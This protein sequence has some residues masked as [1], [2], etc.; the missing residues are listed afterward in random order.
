MLLETGSIDGLPYFEEYNPGEPGKTATNEIARIMESY[1]SLSPHAALG[2]RLAVVDAPDPAAIVGIIANLL[3]NGTCSTAYVRFVVTSGAD[4]AT[5]VPLLNMN[6]NDYVEQVIEGGYGTLNIEIDA[7][8]QTYG[9]LQEELGRQP[10]HLVLLFDPSKLAAVQVP[11]SFSILSP[12][13]LPMKFH[14]DS[15]TDEVQIVPSADEG[16]FGYYNDIRNRL[17]GQLS[18]LTYGAK[19]SLEGSK[20]TVLEDLVKYRHATWLIVVDRPREQH[21]QFDLPRIALLPSGSRDVQVFASSL[22]RFERE[23]RLQLQEDGYE[24]SEMAV[25][26]LVDLLGGL[27]SDGL[28]SLITR[29]RRGDGRVLDFDTSG[30]HSVLSILVAAN[31][32]YEHQHYSDNG[33]LLVGLDSQAMHIWFRL[34]VQKGRALFVGMAV[35]P[36]D[37]S[38]LYVDLLEVKTQ[39]DRQGY[40][41]NGRTIAGEDVRQLLDVADILTAIFRLTQQSSDDEA[42]LL[43]PARRE[44]LRQQLFRECFAIEHRKQ[45][46]YRRR[47]SNLLNQLFDPAKYQERG[48]TLRLWLIDVGLAQPNGLPPTSSFIA[49]ED[50][51]SVNLVHILR[52]QIEQY[53]GRGN[54]EKDVK[55]NASAASAEP[56]SD[57]QHSEDKNVSLELEGDTI[58]ASPATASGTHSLD[59]TV[60]SEANVEAIKRRATELK[61]VLGE[62]G[63]KLLDLNP[64][65]TQIGPSVVR[66]RARLAPG[67]KLRDV[68][69]CAEDVARGLSL[70]SI[71]IIN[72]IPGEPFVAIDIERTDRE[73]VPLEAVLGQLP[74]VNPNELVIACG[75]TPAGQDVP[76]DIVRLPHLLVAGT[77]ESGKTM[78]LCTLLI[79]LLRRY[80]E[81]SLKLLLIDPKVTNFV[82]FEGL[83]HL[84]NKRIYKDA[85]EATE[86]LQEV[87][88]TEVEQRTTQLTRGRQSSISNYNMQYPDQSIPRILV[89]VDEYADLIA[90]LNKTQR[91]AFESS[92]TRLTQRMRSVGIHLVLATQR[93]SV[94]VVTGNLKANMPSRIS[95]LLPSSIDSR[96]ILDQPGAEHLLGRGDMLLL[97][98]QRLQRLQGYFVADN[99]IERLIRS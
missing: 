53:I 14:Y 78:F 9:K 54:Q 96:T 75:R 8:P 70:H 28:L 49:E 62:Y 2:L 16:L 47:W 82:F 31:W 25:K 97:H 77:T 72:N 84:I 7:Q 50:G 63:I 60:L 92:I 5:R 27:V 10:V 57:E 18:G 29:S 46:G 24:P 69:A 34:R 88:I 51:R 98:N 67:T 86:V 43:V 71:P 79:S 68:Q 64:N 80:N 94:D 41:I 48:L 23:F 20:Q 33:C 42:N 65:L 26:A 85:L 74:P 99:D 22:S 38:Q 66:Y 87:L 81:H 11:R 61:R 30:L 15:L 55:A 93:P 3:R 32:Y 44:V 12:L 40:R 52:S 37:E 4:H 59:Q 36:T 89:V 45:R 95:F 6:S 73:I 90:V 39:E 35:D 19:A 91:V 17:S 56:S 83:P 1:L 13:Y 58:S 76:L 21:E